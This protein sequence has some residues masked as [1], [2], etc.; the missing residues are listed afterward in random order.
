MNQNEILKIIQ[1]LNNTNTRNIVIID[2]GNV[3]KWEK[4]LDWKI[5]I[6]KLGHFVKQLSAGKRYL[7]RFYYGLDCGK[8]KM[9]ILTPWSKMV[10]VKAKMSGF[11]AVTKEV[12]YIISNNYRTGYVKKCDMDIEMTV[13]LIK[14][15]KN[16][17]NIILFSGDGDLAYTLKFLKQEYNKSS[18]VVGARGYIGREYFNAYKKRYINEILYIEDFVKRLKMNI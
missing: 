12:K 11:M 5:S 3:V 14:E 18:I 8:G 10:L 9:K 16:Y 7:R 13:D 6:K 2:Y 15:L 17:D 1:N 4:S